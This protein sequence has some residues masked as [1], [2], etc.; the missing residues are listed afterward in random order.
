MKQKIVALLL[1]AAMTV[2]LVTACGT[3]T[4]KNTEDSQNSENVVKGNTEEDTSEGEYYSDEKGNQFYRAAD[5]TEYYVDKSGNMYKRFDDVTLTLLWDWNGG[6]NTPEDQYNCEFNTAIRE[7]LG[8]TVV[9]E[10]VYADEAEQMNMLF[11]SGEY[12]DIIEAP[13]WG[14]IAATTLSL[15]K[16][17][18]DG[19]FYDLSEM[20]QDYNF[21]YQAYEVG[22][23][24]TEAYWKN[25]IDV[26]DGALYVMPARL[27]G[28]IEQYSPSNYALCVRADVAET[29]GVDP[30]NIHTPEELYEFLKAADEYGFKDVN[31][32]DTITL[33]TGKNGNQFYYLYKMFSEKRWTDYLLSEDGTVNYQWLDDEYCIDGSLYIWNLVKE[34]IMDVECFTQSDDL[35]TQKAGNG[36]AL[37][38]AGKYDSAVLAQVQTGMFDAYPEMRYVPVGPLSYTDG[39]TLKSL[40][41]GGATGSHV[42]C[43]PETCSNIEAALTWVDYMSS[44]EAY[45][46]NFG[47]NGVNYNWDGSIDGETGFTWTDEYLQSVAEDVMAVL[48]NM[49]A[50]GYQIS[51]SPVAYNQQEWFGAQLNLSAE[52]PEYLEYVNKWHDL[53]PVELSTGTTISSYASDYEYY[54]EA[55]EVLATYDIETTLTQAFFADTEE[56]AEAIIRKWQN[57][58]LKS[59]EYTGLLE[60]LTECY[61]ADPDNTTF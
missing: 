54:A 33:S 60:H 42:Y 4:Q 41:E 18:E 5:G 8:I 61:K 2:G 12:P 17:F 51:R 43:F 47:Q 26:W 21:L 35:A 39:D 52:T 58:V 30:Q 1:I 56:E 7:K 49:K 31:G 53:S 13:Y 57:N 28:S 25:D 9:Y 55:T 48:E 46:M 37:F 38:I 32:N 59:E 6:A 16:A 29:L 19:T 22:T 44:P 36:T 15:N 24:I 50:E 20:Y 10:E 34:G 40:E 23:T 14:G 11:A 3:E 27:D 45:L